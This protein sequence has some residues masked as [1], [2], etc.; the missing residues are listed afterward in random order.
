M[1]ATWAVQLDSE[2]GLRITEGRID[3]GERA[4]RVLLWK[5][6]AFLLHID[7]TFRGRIAKLQE[8]RA[9]AENHHLSGEVERFNSEI[10]NLQAMQVEGGWDECLIYRE[11]SVRRMS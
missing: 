1:S 5:D 9:E 7:G 3:A 4:P 2:D 6:R 10:R 11:V 8:D